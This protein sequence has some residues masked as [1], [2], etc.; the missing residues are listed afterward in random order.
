[1]VITEAT[2]ALTTNNEPSTTMDFKMYLESAESE[3][4]KAQCSRNNRKKVKEGIVRAYDLHKAAEAL[5]A[6]LSEERVSSNSI[7]KNSFRVNIDSY[8]SEMKKI[9][10]VPP[11]L[12]NTFEKHLLEFVEYQIEHDLRD[13]T[14]VPDMKI[15]AWLQRQ[16]G[17]VSPYIDGNRQNL[18][19][20]NLERAADHHRL[21]GKH[22]HVKWALYTVRT[23]DDYL[24]EL[25]EFKA[26]HGHLKVRRIQEN[27]KVGEW[28]AK[29]RKEYDQF[30]RGEKVANLSELRIAELDAM[31]FI[32]RIRSARPR[33]GDER[34][35]LRRKSK[36]AQEAVEESP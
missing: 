10:E 18:K 35:R 5:E 9:L 25:I 11:N 29:I 16:R 14:K 26:K 33:K 23:Y 30:K 8:K 34:F 15:N 4:D 20:D 27:S 12:L 28:V 2:V 7:L 36:D 6:M 17:I 24:G 31:G 21:L 22:L 1:V 19:G 13:V 32:W 3:Y